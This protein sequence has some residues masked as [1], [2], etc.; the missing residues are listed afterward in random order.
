MIWDR[1]KAIRNQ[2]PEPVRQFVRVLG[3]QTVSMAGDLTK[4]VI[5]VAAAGE[6]EP[7]HVQAALHAYFSGQREPPGGA[8]EID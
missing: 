8:D 6:L 4:Q 5:E 3:I 1:A 2:K 7:R